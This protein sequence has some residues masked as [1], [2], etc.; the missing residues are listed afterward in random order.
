VQR[1]WEADKCRYQAVGVERHQK[2][3]RHVTFNMWHVYIGRQGRMRLDG[4]ITGS[5]QLEWSA[6]K[7]GDGASNGASD[8]TYRATAAP[9]VAAG[10]TADNAANGSTNLLSSTTSCIGHRLGGSGGATSRAL[11][12]GGA[13]RARL[14]CASYSAGGGGQG[15]SGQEGDIVGGCHLLHSLGGLVDQRLGLRGELDR[16]ADAVAA[17]CEQGG[18]AGGQVREAV[19]TDVSA[20]GRDQGGHTKA[21]EALE[22]HGQGMLI[23]VLGQPAE[24]GT[25]KRRSRHCPHAANRP[26]CYPGHPPQPIQLALLTKHGAN[27][28][29]G[30]HVGHHMDAACRAGGRGRHGTWETVGRHAACNLNVVSKE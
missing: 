4:H 11:L 15:I 2:A 27:C 17:A 29:A 25:C 23:P 14:G 26:G 18:R 19:G 28:D 6:N 16:W 5:G 30:L 1:C 7:A 9:G 22:K 3:G 24:H 20:A 8:A 21:I 12:C 13:S 10:D